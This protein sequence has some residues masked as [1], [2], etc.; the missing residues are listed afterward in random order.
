VIS[1]GIESLRSKGG[2]RGLEEADELSG[3][4]IRSRMVRQVGVHR[5]GVRQGDIRDAD[6][7]PCVN[8]KPDR[9]LPT[10]CDTFALRRDI[11][12][13]LVRREHE[14]VAKVGLAVLARVGEGK[15]AL[16]GSPAWIVVVHVQQP[17][18]C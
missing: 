11:K 15:E 3:G 17:K 13:Q 5:G 6:K 1:P 18:H 12:A 7:R 14:G 8:S 10:Q 4:G 9:V 2:E 16:S